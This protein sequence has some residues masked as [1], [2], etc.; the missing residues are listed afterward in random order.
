[1]KGTDEQGLP[2]MSIQMGHCSTDI[3]ENALEEKGDR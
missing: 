2:H 1:V 3:Y